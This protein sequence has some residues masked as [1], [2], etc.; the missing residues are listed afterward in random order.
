MVMDIAGRKLEFR[1]Q[2]LTE[3]LATAS[4]GESCI[5]FLQLSQCSTSTFQHIESY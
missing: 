5:C 2:K 3:E 1:K 4:A